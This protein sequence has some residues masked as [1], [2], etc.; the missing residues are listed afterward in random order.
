MGYCKPINTFN[1]GIFVELNRVKISSTTLS[2]STAEVYFSKLLVLDSYLKRKTMKM[3]LTMMKMKMKTKK[4]QT[5]MK[6]KI[7]AKRKK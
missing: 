5:I 7:L 2:A 3:K 6:R 1:F 4:M